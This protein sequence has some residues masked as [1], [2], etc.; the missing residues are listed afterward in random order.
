MLRVPNCANRYFWGLVDAGLRMATCAFL[1]ALVNVADTHPSTSV[2][3]CR[4]YSLSRVGQVVLQSLV[5]ELGTIFIGQL[6]LDV[7]A[8]LRQGIGARIEGAKFIEV[9]FH[10][11]LFSGARLFHKG[12]A[13][14]VHGKLQAP[15][16]LLALFGGQPN[17]RSTETTVRS[18]S[19]R[20]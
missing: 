2:E 14:E 16:R 13:M 17:Q 9:F 19:R 6:I 1:S 20:R 12:S 7:N 10:L 18:V 11:Q 5:F 3:G 15:T 8:H 4:S